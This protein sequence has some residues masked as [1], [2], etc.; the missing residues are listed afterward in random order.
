MKQ[1]IQ[2]YRSGELWLAD[3]PGPALKSGGVVVRT[4]ASLVSA[5][6]ERMIVELAKKS[7]IGKAQA[8]PDLVRKVIDKIRT[9]GLA[10]TMTKVFAKLDTPIP[11]GY[12]CAGTVVEAGE[13]S[14]L[15]AGDRVACAGAGYATHAEYNFIPRNL[16][17]KARFFLGEMRD[18]KQISSG[19]ASVSRL[20]GGTNG[21]AVSVGFG[22]TTMESPATPSSRRMSSASWALD[23]CQVS[24]RW[25]PTHAASR[26]NV[27]FFAALRAMAPAEHSPRGAITHAGS[28]GILPRS[29]STSGAMENL[30]SKRLLR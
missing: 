1:I 28:P 13:R 29:R 14:G 4:A 30:G 20:V 8:R 16:S 7:L 25:R 24:R 11:L 12:S 2:S 23:A 22:A 5:G 15:R 19:V 17:A 9:E 18:R 27:R 6:T 10:P 26:R 21:P 3:V